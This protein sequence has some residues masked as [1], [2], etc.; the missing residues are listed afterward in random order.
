MLHTMVGVCCLFIIQFML[1]LI[2]SDPAHAQ[3]AAETFSI[4]PSFTLQMR[5][6]LSLRRARAQIVGNALG[7]D[8]RYELDVSLSKGNT[9]ELSLKDFFLE[10]TVNP[11]LHWQGGLFKIPLSEQFAVSGTQQ[12][13]TERSI[14]HQAFSPGRATGFSLFGDLYTPTWFYQVGVFQAP[15]S[16]PETI[17]PGFFG[18]LQYEPW[19][20]YGRGE[21]DW[22]A[23][24]QARMRFK[25]ALWQAPGL[26][27]KASVF[28]GVKWRGGSLNTHGFGAW[29]SQTFHWGAYA[30]LGYFLWFQRL[31]AVARSA[32]LSTGSF[33]QEY[34]VGLNYYFQDHRFKLQSDYRWL[35]KETLTQQWL[36]QVQV[37]F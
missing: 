4:T 5:Q 16:P 29:E 34:A 36:A 25:T 9:S 24:H 20:A 13:F 26:S 14:A 23:T 12:Q 30:Q 6:D 1:Q 10:Y 33:Q 22:E 37:L 17:K 35:V 28:G 8:L 18:S 19:G 31:E 7:P 27:T 21:S 15:E 3:D 32:F 2:T 11:G